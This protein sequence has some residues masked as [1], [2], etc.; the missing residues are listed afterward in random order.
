MIILVGISGRIPARVSKITC[1]RCNAIK[2]F[3]CVFLGGSFFGA[4]Y[5]A[6]ILSA[7]A[8]K[9]SNAHCRITVFT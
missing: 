6:S 8:L 5:M 3:C 4:K 9:T 1:T 2:Q 7:L